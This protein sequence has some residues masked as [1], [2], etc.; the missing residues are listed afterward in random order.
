MA[1]QFWLRGVDISMA[2]TPVEITSV[3]F[4]KS[5]RGYDVEEVDEFL[6]EIS[7]DYEAIYRENQEQRE[8]IEDLKE[9]LEKYNELEKTLNDTLILAQRTAEDTKANS[10]KEANLIIRE[11]KEKAEQIVKDAQKQVEDEKEKLEE[12]KKNQQVFIAE[13]KSLLLTQLE[14]LEKKSAESMSENEEKDSGQ[15]NEDNYEVEYVG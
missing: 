7:R 13:S 15:D 8:K 1:E 2:K 12:I 11:A 5:V 3:K 4:S 14:L 9:T 6:H 10:E